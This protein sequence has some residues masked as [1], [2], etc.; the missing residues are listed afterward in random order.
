MKPLT[1]DILEDGMEKFFFVMINHPNGKPE[2]TMIM[3]NGDEIAFFGTYEEA[4]R[5]AIFN[6]AAATYG[7]EIFQLGEGR[8]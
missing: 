5:S 6:L 8:Q 1:K 3:E 7:Y 4:K 2:D